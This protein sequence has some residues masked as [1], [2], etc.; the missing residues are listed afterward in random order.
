MWKKYAYLVIH[1]YWCVK[2]SIEVHFARSAAINNRM[3]F[4]PLHTNKNAKDIIQFLI[5]RNCFTLNLWSCVAI[6]SFA[7]DHKK[8]QTDI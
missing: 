4:R 6:E 3:L 8:N 1:F 5:Y 7:T 2:A